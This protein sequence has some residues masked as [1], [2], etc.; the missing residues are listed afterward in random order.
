MAGSTSPVQDGAAALKKYTVL[1]GRALPTE[2]PDLSSGDNSRAINSTPGSPAE[3]SNLEGAIWPDKLKF[4]KSK[5]R[6][7][8]LKKPQ[9]AEQSD[10]MRASASKFFDVSKVSA[11]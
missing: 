8:Q 1:R 2:S 5:S 7:K 4:T 3:A 11:S 6:I 9:F 10:V